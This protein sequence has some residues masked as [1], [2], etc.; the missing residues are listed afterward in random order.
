MVIGQ[1]K[2]TV[3]PVNNVVIPVPPSL[4]VQVAPPPVIPTLTMD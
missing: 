4:V 2:G 3:L 1:I